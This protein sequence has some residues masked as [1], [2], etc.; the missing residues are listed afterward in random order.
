MLISQD[1]IGSTISH[2]NRFFDFFF[3]FFLGQGHN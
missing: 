2:G 1:D 3:F